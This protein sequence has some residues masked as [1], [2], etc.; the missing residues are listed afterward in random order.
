[1]TKR[2]M[3][4][5]GLLLFSFSLFSQEKEEKEGKEE[6]I[7]KHKFVDF[8]FITPNNEALSLSSINTDYTLIYFYNPECEVC[9]KIKKRLS[10]NEHL[11]LMIDKKLLTVLA[12]LPDVKKEY[13]LENTKFIP[14]NWL[15]GW[16]E[17]DKLIIKA[18]LKTVPTFFLLDKNRNI[19][20]NSETKA[21]Q[22]WID[23]ER[24]HEDNDN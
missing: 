10:T 16:I 22:N 12:I 4:L 2:I 7:E 9:S 14:K 3:I 24:N 11:N 15:N 17:N 1:M 23:E 8:D 18:Y 6:N 21:I 13:W 5:L 20:N 19:L